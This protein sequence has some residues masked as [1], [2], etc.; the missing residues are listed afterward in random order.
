[1]ANIPP[2]V[3]GMFPV[4]L[5]LIGIATGLIEVILGTQLGA[6]FYKEGEAPVT[7]VAGT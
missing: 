5:M 1:M 3:L 7:K 2:A 4:R 6:S